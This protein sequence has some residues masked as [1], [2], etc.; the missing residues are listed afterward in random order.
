LDWL[1]GVLTMAG[2]FGEDSNMKKNNRA[3]PGRV[4]LERKRKLVEGVVK[5][6]QKKAVVP[7]SEAAMK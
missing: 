4:N 5:F 3:E 7:G 1:K 2:A 6:N